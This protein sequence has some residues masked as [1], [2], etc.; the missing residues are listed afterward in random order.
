MTRDPV[1]A[2]PLLHALSSA[3]SIRAIY[4]PKHPRV[5]EA[6]RRTRGDLTDCLDDRGADEITI[7]IIDR[8]LLVDDRPIRA[9]LGHLASLV[10]TITRRGI[11]RLTFSR[12][13][14]D[15]E[16]QRL[17]DGL[18]GSSEPGS[19]PHIVLGT[20]KLEDALGSEEEEEARPEW[21]WGDLAEADVD[22]ME[23]SFMRFRSDS[24]GSIEE[25]DRLLWRFVEN[26]DQTSRSLLVLA[27]M[28]TEDQRLFIHSINVSLL[29]LAQGRGL[30]IEGQTLHDIGFAALLHDIGMLS[31][32]RSIFERTGHRYSDL[33]W[34]LVTRH[35]ELGAAQ[36]CGLPGA[37]PL[38]VIVAYEHH[39]R[40]DG[41][42]SFPTPAV[43]RLPC[44]ASQLT[45]IG[46]TYDVMIAGRG[47][48]GGAG[49]KEALAVWQERSE[50]FLDPFLVGNF[51][52]TLIEVGG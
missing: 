29:A 20:I 5:G 34:E 15:D 28:K 42:P 18:S 52:M 3:V 45:A 16:F 31:L 7:L 4:P 48:A 44:L 21:G 46:D 24:E 49:G 37:P 9:H 12:D 2:L 6:I 1:Q 14:E 43:P 50:T 33:E 38:A 51:M 30:G 11:E 13:V 22:R 10:R 17:I 8:E 41:K 36:M 27:P 26:M 47:L 25:L 35:P 32:P 19:S 23:D 40:W 39:L